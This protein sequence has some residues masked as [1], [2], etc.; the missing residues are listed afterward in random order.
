MTPST[1]LPRALIILINRH[2]KMT[3]LHTWLT[4]PALDDIHNSSTPAPKPADETG[5]SSQRFMV[6]VVATRDG[7]TRRIAA[8]RRDIYGFS[9]VL[10][11]EGIERL[12]NAEIRSGGAYPPGEVF[13][14]HELLSALEP[15]H[16]RLEF[17]RQ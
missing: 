8:E 2:V 6:D 17:G 10:V 13:K 11:F 12:L 4:R 15:H 16:L 9:A 1:L 3:E 7:N 14:A 5:L